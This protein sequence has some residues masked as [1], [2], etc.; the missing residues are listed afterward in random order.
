MGT[1]QIGASAPE[2]H[3]E[4]CHQHSSRMFLPLFI[5]TMRGTVYM[6]M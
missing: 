6:Y 5:V 3:E 2:I 4:W 1:H